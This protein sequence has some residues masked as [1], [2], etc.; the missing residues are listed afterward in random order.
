LRG[1]GQASTDGLAVYQ[2]RAGPAHANATTFLRTAESQI[3]A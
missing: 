2:Y 3:I 1:Q